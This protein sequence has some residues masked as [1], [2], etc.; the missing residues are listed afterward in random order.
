MTGSLGLQGSFLVMPTAL[1][2]ILSDESDGQPINH[3]VR[4]AP[5]K[6]I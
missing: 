2:F 6:L 3:V 4:V 1:T 5:E